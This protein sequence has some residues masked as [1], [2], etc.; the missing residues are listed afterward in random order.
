MPHF[1][2]KIDVFSKDGFK[3]PKKKF[4]SGLTIAGDGPEV[5]P[6]S[7]QSWIRHCIKLSLGT[8]ACSSG[9]IWGTR[10]PH[11]NPVPMNFMD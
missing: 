4:A 3:R 6:P 9:T 8:I 10:S 7:I 2:E 1:H 5:R 11:A